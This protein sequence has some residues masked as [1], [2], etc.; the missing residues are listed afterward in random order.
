VVAD[1]ARTGRGGGNLAPMLPQ[2]RDGA[3]NAVRVCLGV[4]PQDRVAVIHDRDRADIARALEEEARSAGAAVHSWR[5]EDWVDRP[6]RE[7]P[8]ALA[9]ELI[10]FAP[11]VSFFAGG[12]MEGELAFRQ[13]MRALLVERL[14]CRHGHMIGITPELM[15]DG[16]AGDYELVYRRT[17]DVYEAVR[18]ASVIEVRTAL[19]TDLRATLDPALRWVP[20]HGRYHEQ[21][22]WGNLPEG[23]VFTSPRSVDGVLAGEELGD[24]FTER[25]G[26]LAEPARFELE[27]GRV[28]SVTTPDE[29]LRRDIEAYLGQHP[30]SNRAGEFAIGT[31]VG[32][33]RIVGNFLQDEKFPGVHIAFGDPYG[34]ETG[35]DW[36][37]PSHVDVLASHADVTVDGRRIMREGVIVI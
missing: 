26:L 37:A 11:T 18:N 24:H 9:Q 8:E 13:P 28:R 10:E 21:G 14:H 22:Q 34:P 35:A 19:G 3:R 30:E 6:A 31:N 20:C 17:C 5:M 16:M 4:G 29:A 32:L 12:G 27:G 1:Q 25:Y 2:Y 36:S 15:S 7:F 33:T 23:E